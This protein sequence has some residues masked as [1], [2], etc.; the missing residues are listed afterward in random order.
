MKNSV[1]RIWL[2]VMGALLVIAFSLIAVACG[3][4]KKYT[5]TFEAG[6]GI[7]AVA[8]LE[9][10]AGEEIAEPQI[11][12]KEGYNFIGWYDN[13]DFAG[14]KVQFPTVMPKEN[15]TY[16]AKSTPIAKGTLAI[17]V[18]NGGTFGA[19]TALSHQLYV[20]TNVAQFMESFV[21][22]HPLTLTQDAI[23]DGWYIGNAKLSD[24]LT[25]TEG[26]VTLTAKYKVEYAVNVYVQNEN[27]DE[28]VKDSEQSFTASDYLGKSFD[29]EDFDIDLASHFGFNG[30]LSS[31][32]LT[33]STDKSANVFNAYYEWKTVTVQFRA[34][35]PTVTT[36]DGDVTLEASGKVDNMTVRMN[37]QFT[38]PQNNYTLDGYRFAGWSRS[39]NGALLGETTSTGTSRT[40]YIYALWNKG[41]TDLNGGTDLIFD[42]LEE[43]NTVVLRRNGL[44]EKK[45][46]YDE[47]RVFTFTLDDETTT[48]KGKI[49]EDGTFTYYISN[50]DKTYTVEEWTE[51][52]ETRTGATL[53]LDGLDGAVYVQGGN[54]VNGTYRFDFEETCF[55][56]TPA[57]GEEGSFYF[58]LN[59]TNTSFRVRDE[60]TVKVA[61]QPVDVEYVEV[62]PTLTLDGF[63]NLTYQV[64]ADAE[65]I[66]STYTVKNVYSEQLTLDTTAGT[67]TID[68]PKSIISVVQDEN[69]VLASEYQIRTARMI[70]DNQYLVLAVF[71]QK[72]TQEVT[73]SF[74]V[75]EK[76]MTF[77]T[78]G[79]ENAY[80]A[81]DGAEFNDDDYF[82]YTDEGEFNDGETTWKFLRFRLEGSTYTV[83]YDG[84]DGSKATRVGNETGAYD[85]QFAQSEY[86]TQAFF[87]SDNVNGTGTVVL[88][89]QEGDG[90]VEVAKGT[91]A[92]GA[93]ADVYT[94]G[95]LDFETGYQEIANFYN[96]KN[97]RVYSVD[98]LFA[99]QDESAK[100]YVFELQ[101]ENYQLACNGYGQA[102]FSLGEAFEDVIYYV[103][104][105]YTFNGAT[106]EFI[107]FIYGSSSFV[108]R[109][110][111][112]ADTRVDATFLS[113]PYPVGEYYDDGDRLEGDQ[114]FY[115]FYDGH[116]R[117]FEKEGEAYTKL[118]AEGDLVAAN[119]YHTFEDKTGT[120]VEKYQT[121]RFRA[122]TEGGRYSFGTYIESEVNLSKEDGRVQLDGYGFANAFN[123]NYRYDVDG[124]VVKLYHLGEE[125]TDAVFT[126]VIEGGK[127]VEP[128]LA[129]GAFIGLS[130]DAN[131]NMSLSDYSVNLDGAG[132][133]T[134]VNY[135]TGDELA[136]GTYVAGT[137]GKDSYVF[138]FTGEYESH[139]GLVRMQTVYDAYNTPYDVYLYGNAKNAMNYTFEDGARLEVDAFN[140]REYTNAAGNKQT[141]YFYEVDETSLEGKKI[142]ALVIVDMLSDDNSYYE[143]VLNG[144]FLVE[145]ENTEARTATL[146]AMTS[147]FGKFIRYNYDGT[148]TRESVLTLD[149][150]GGATFTEN[151][152]NKTGTYVEGDDGD[153][154]VI[155]FTDDTT[156]RVVLR[157]GTMD[158]ERLEVYIVYDENRDVTYTSATWEV[159]ICN[160]YGEVTYIDRNGIEHLLHYTEK[161]EGGIN[162]TGSH[163]DELKDEWFE[164]PQVVL[165]ETDKTFT[166]APQE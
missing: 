45:A 78:N 140:T 55:K 103:E 35:E 25:M 111:V 89:V 72:T 165:N 87:N 116:A 127:L 31:T 114:V 11:Q 40:L 69:S 77:Q 58:A 120:A 48:L 97:F 98:G 62:Y 38:L 100:T 135:E 76:T 74:A 149:G 112:S 57:T 157:T 153:E 24:T 34:N 122:T 13:A 117:V 5:V 159:L 3:G 148:I 16:Y 4:A 19:G 39:A 75:G 50:F 110:P 6:E 2:A 124:E 107:V 133:A 115:L 85:E 67:E 79:Y 65:I 21:E 162:L 101:G 63:G 60:A 15:V 137:E 44:G 83:R 68:V 146:K 105:G 91:Y 123:V 113:S 51:N 139:S 84:A 158:G 130:V 142:V 92:K 118:V 88:F 14:S 90:F 119:D 81:Y 53:K 33:L 94:F 66:T 61:Y 32:G 56:F 73:L 93:E 42:L 54:T 36:D 106:Y 161:E 147:V 96:G 29:E 151:G 104:E 30:N 46:T 20:G 136:T 129:F 163:Y 80:Y 64:D 134:L 28:Y 82:I 22:E 143:V 43:E 99:M 86:R 1:R 164:A 41:A 109:A 155:T 128:T 166:F 160:G 59:N 131:G 141:V 71:D 70:A 145:N 9:L 8:S 7:E 95:T 49:F 156:M 108:L 17:V 18:G 152:S 138:T 132:V 47:N 23:F 27:D 150:Q 144:Y 154:Y 26:G 126:F 52:V 121:V 102:R 37:S 125:F 10:E 12:V